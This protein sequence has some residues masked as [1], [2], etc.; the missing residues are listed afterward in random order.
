LAH[1]RIPGALRTRR[2]AWIVVAC[3]FVYAVVFFALRRDESFREETFATAPALAV[4]VDLYIDELSFDPVR[5]AIEMRFDL[6]SGSTVGGVRYGGPLNRD[7]ELS[8]RDGDS[9]QIVVFRRNGATSTHT[10]SLDLHG[11]IA[12]Y[13]FDR[14]RSDITLSVRDLSAHG[15]LPIPIR[16]TVWEGIS[17]WVSGIRASPAPA[18][19]GLMLALTVRRP[20]PIV[21]LT[22][23]LYS[24]MV[25]VAVCSLCLGGLVFAGARKVEST[26]IGA[27]VA[28][29]FSITVLRNVLPGSP[30]IG[31]SADIIIFLWV[32]VAVITGL[33]L[34]VTAWVK[35]GPGA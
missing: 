8:I 29:V 12:T 15:G 31:V 33:S 5:Q 14:Y 11:A 23:I 28:M 30:P 6:A 3:L 24:L 35:R 18:S 22:V 7:T 32:E 19:G 9:E 20:L 16:A 25:V 21:A 1:P 4:P 17:G 34:L 13:P 2:V 27:L 10:V 26:I